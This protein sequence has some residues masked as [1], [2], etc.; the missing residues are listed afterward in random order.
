MGAEA[1]LV[2]IQLVSGTHAIATALAAVLRPGDELLA[3]AGRHARAS[4]MILATPISAVSMYWRPQAAAGSQP[5]AEHAP[6][7]AQCKRIS[8][9]VATTLLQPE[10]MQLDGGGCQAVPSFVPALL[11]HSYRGQPW[12]SPPELLL[13]FVGAA[14]M[15]LLRR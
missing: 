10:P 14:R 13:R 2:R 11:M 1:A 12:T 8:S 7:L 9:Q 4:A 3:V 6:A 15:T 5:S